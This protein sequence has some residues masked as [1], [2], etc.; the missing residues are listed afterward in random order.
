MGFVMTAQEKQRSKELLSTAIGAFANMCWIIF[1]ISLWFFLLCESG[2]V[3]PDQATHQPHHKVPLSSRAPNQVWRWR[4]GA[5]K[6]SKG[7]YSDLYYTAGHYAGGTAAAL[8]CRVMESSA[9]A[10][11][12]EFRHCSHFSHLFQAQ[13]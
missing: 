2:V 1:F 8:P 10:E 3:A 7:N 13:K 11:T 12:L 4:H 5:W 6:E 9:K